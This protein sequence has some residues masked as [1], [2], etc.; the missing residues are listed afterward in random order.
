V[1]FF[2]CW[3]LSVAP[4]VVTAGSSSSS[5]F[6]LLGSEKASEVGVV[7]SSKTLPWPE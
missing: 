6:W 7:S 3:A 4:G 1:C 5:A 2:S